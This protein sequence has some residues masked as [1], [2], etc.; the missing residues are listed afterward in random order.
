MD[1]DQIEHDRLSKIEDKIDKLIDAVAK[2]VLIESRV[3]NIEKRQ[4]KLESK[5]DDLKTTFYRY[6]YTA[7]GGVTALASGYEFLKFLGTH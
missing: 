4:D 6:A 5:H 3:D 1:V 7:I 2:F